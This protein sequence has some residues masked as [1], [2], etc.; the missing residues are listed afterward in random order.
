[1]RKY[2]KE[3]GKEG[4]EKIRGA[5]RLGKALSAVFGWPIPS[6][7]KGVPRRFATPVWMGWVG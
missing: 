2:V 7:R 3:Q 4:R 1:M 5:R 6:S